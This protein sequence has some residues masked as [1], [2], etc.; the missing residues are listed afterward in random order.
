LILHEFSNDFA[1]SPYA[2]FEYFDA[3]QRRMSAPVVDRFARLYVTPGVN[4]AGYE[5]NVPADLDVL[6]LLEQ[7]VEH[8]RPPADAVVQT[9]QTPVPPFSVLA[10][11]PMCRYPAYARYVGTG[12][13]KV[14]ASYSCTPVP[15]P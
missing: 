10:S 4:H 14:A 15:M 2:G 13:P 8:G 1:Q 3:M 7:W 12:D 9:L 6:G 11:K 5:P